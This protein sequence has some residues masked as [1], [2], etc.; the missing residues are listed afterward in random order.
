[1]REE[2]ESVCFCSGDVGCLGG[3]LLI[4]IKGPTHEGHKCGAGE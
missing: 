4:Q 2:C 1:M 3:Q